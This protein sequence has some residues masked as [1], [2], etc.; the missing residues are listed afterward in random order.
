MDEEGPIAFELVLKLH[1]KWMRMDPISFQLLLVGVGI[2]EGGL[3][4][5]E[6]IWSVHHGFGWVMG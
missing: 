6:R 3:I 4:A 1:L 5:F 2:L